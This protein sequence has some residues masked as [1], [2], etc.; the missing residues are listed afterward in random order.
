MWVPSHSE[1]Y[2]QPG[3]PEDNIPVQ[4]SEM[5]IVTINSKFNPSIMAQEVKHPNITSQDPE[6]SLKF[7]ETRFGLTDF[8]LI[9]TVSLALSDC[10]TNSS[11]SG[12]KF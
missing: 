9:D 7:S 2:T 6:V 3:S 12:S 5:T 4:P 10:E 11:W 1:D 8:A